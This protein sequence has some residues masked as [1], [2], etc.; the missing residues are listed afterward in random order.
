M[1]KN[2]VGIIG[3]GS[4]LPEKIVTNK[5]LEKMVDTNDEW[6]RS[7]TGIVERR[8]L[9]EDKATSFMCIKA[10]E[11]ALKDA[12]LCPEDIDLIIVTTI[13][14]DMAFPSTGCIVQRELGCTNAAAF[15]LEAACSGFLYGMS[16][17]YGYINSGIY[18]NVLVISADALSKIIDWKDRNTCILFGDGAGAVVMSKVEHGGIL[19][20]DIGADGKGAEYLKQPAGGS[21]YPATHETVDQ[22]LHYVQMEGN[23]VFKFAVKIMDEA[24][25]KVIQ[26]SGLELSDIDYLIPHQANIRIINAARKRLKMTEDKVFVNL[27]KYGNM[28]AASIPVALDEALKK[29]N[30]KNGDNVL[31]V[32]FGGGL[33][34]G[35]CVL[36]WHR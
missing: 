31:L 8:I 6:I 30:I 16:V 17:A 35:S 12:G 7:R 9:D 36:E 2:K 4:Y 5:E 33:T 23:G 27:D 14:P 24:S 18:K 3:I 34:W 25:K 26:K 22:R 13:T 19:A 28:S 10:G 21:L 1:E 29:G 15:D 20:I 32:G 11:L